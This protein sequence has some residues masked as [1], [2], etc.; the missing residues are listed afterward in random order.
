MRRMAKPWCTGWLILCCFHLFG[1]T[2]SHTCG[3][4]LVHNPAVNYGQVTDI[5]GNAYRTVV[6][7]DLVWF[8]E[9]LKVTRF[10]NGDTIPHVTDA[11]LWA[12][13]TGPGMC[14][15]KND[16]TFDCPQGK[17][18]NFHVA[19]DTRNPCPIGWRVPSITDYDNL[20]NHFDPD[21]NGGAPSSLPNAAGGFLKSA[22]LSYWQSP[23]TMANNQS[24][25]SALPN[26]GRNN[27]GVFSFTN[28]TAASYWYSTPLGPGMGFF[29]QLPYNQEFAVRNAYFDRYGC[30]IRCV[31]D[32]STVQI[33]ESHI[34]GFNVYPNP[35]R[36]FI[37]ISADKPMI[38]QE[39]VISDLTGRPLLRGEILAEDMTISIHELPSGMYFLGFPSSVSGV[40]KIIKQ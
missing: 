35:A 1:Q 32:L 8:A 9:N 29:L 36:E 17:L 31:K 20:I 33:D 10:Q 12:G 37:R 16:T 38:G 40:S 23:N 4:A 26:G 7:D 34:P 19:K 22:G 3:S 2:S 24:G 28:N 21:A 5:D 14:S 13:L 39:Y 11:A 18:Y 27:E 6:I 30:C 15:Y 25:F